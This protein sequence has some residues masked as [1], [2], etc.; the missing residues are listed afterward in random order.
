LWWLIPDV[1]AGMP[2]PYIHPERRLNRGGAL[3]LTYY[4]RVRTHAPIQIVEDAKGR[5]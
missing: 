3:N 4:N 1:L 5:G 2:M